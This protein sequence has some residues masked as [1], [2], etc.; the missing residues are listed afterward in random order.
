MPYEQLER[1]ELLKGLG[2]FMYGFAQPGGLVNY[3]TKRPG[4]DPVTSVDVGYRTDG[5]LSTHVDLSRR[6]GPD[7]MFGARLNY[8]KEA[9]KTYNAGDINRNSVSLALDGQLTR[10]LQVW[11]NALYQ[12]V[13]SSGQTPAI[14]T[15]SYTASSLPAVISGGTNLLGG[16]D[17][18]I[19]TNLQLYTAGVR[20]EISPD[21]S[22]TTS[23][24]YSKSAR[25][26]REHAHA[27]QPG[28]RLHRRAVKRR[29][30]PSGHL[31]ARHVRGQG[32]NGAAHASTRD[33]RR[34]PVS[35]QHGGVSG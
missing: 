6:F 35:D 5:V 4:K 2:G 12:T 7:D 25:P 24:S 27:A 10:D 19:N 9:G 16:T 18:H 22:F 13:R 33:W 28:R 20:Y 23:G 29:R 32:E 8:T 34:V 21:W 26:Q 3:V 14:Y 30:S 15:G 1:V 31:L 17:Q 11:F